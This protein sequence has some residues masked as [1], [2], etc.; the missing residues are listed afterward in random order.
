MKYFVRLVFGFLTLCNLLLATSA[1]AT[2]I[3]VPD[4]QSTIQEGINTAV[5]GDTVLVAPGIYLENI[6]FL[7][8]NITVASH[9]LLNQDYNAIVE[10]VINGSGAANVDTSS[11]VL[12][13]NDETSEAVLQG[14]TLTGG[15]GT[16]WIDPSIPTYTWRSGG[17]VFISC[18]SPTIRNNRFV[19]NYVAAIGGVDGASGGGLLTF[20]GNPTIINNLFL[21]NRA[22]YGGGVVTDYSGAIIR[23]NVID[24]NIAAGSYGGAGYWNIGN[25]TEPVLLE[26]NTIINNDSN[27]SGGAIRLFS[28]TITVTNNI[29]WG[30]EQSSGGPIS[31]GN[32]NV[33]FCNVEG[34]FTGEGN[35]DQEPCL[36][37]G[38]YYLQDDSPCI[39]TGSLFPDYN[40]PE[41]PDA[42]NQALWPA[43]G[44]VRNDMGAYG[45]PGSC[46]FLENMNGME[47]EHEGTLPVTFMTIQNYP[48]PFNAATRIEY[49]LRQTSDITI[50]IYNA[51]GR[52]MMREHLLTQSAGRYSYPLT[53]QG[54]ASG[55]YFYR[56]T[57]NGQSVT[58]RLVLLR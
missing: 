45:G 22:I 49:E 54:Q 13:I 37:E 14:F 12:F 28:G 33:T 35:I 52:E 34:G 43:R 17:G 23:N 8:K 39:D 6:S 55:I 3:H 18:A 10:T 4:D 36:V 38:L 41:D 30:N 57:G 53:L 50:V 58:Q 26:N 42:P 25:G 15:G 7:G 11:C 9:Y 46:V 32:P 21:E 20:R 2:I 40:D 16:N 29:I 51:A 19:G 44:E 47:E 31:G 24:A 56:I 5:D 48:N 27:T 1:F